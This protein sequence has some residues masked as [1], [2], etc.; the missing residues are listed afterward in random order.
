MKAA[1][2]KPQVYQCDVSVLVRQSGFLVAL[3]R[4][5]LTSPPARDLDIP[6]SKLQLLGIYQQLETLPKHWLDLKKLSQPLGLFPSNRRH[7]AILVYSLL[8]A[9]A[10]Y[11]NAKLTEG[12]LARELGTN[13]V[14]SRMVREILDRF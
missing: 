14:G 2:F 7:A 13:I 11:D 4:Q 10:A 6:F 3:A 8:Q 12:E 9:K 5:F 1:N